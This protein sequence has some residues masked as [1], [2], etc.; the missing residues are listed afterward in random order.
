[1]PP[2]FVVNLPD[3]GEMFFRH[4]RGDDAAP[5]LVLIHGWTASADVQ[6]FTSYRALQDGYSFLAVDVRGHGR[7]LR[8]EETFTLE[9]AADDIGALLRE[10]G[11]REAILVGYSMGGPLSLLTAH[12][13]PGL[14][15]GLVLCATALDFR[16]AGDRVQW[17][18]LRVI[19]SLFRSRTWA[20][21]GRR[22]LRRL[23]RRRPD[24]APFLPWIGAELH[25]ADPVALADGARALRDYDAAPF[26]GSLG[27]P[28]A[29]LVTTKDRQVRPD[30]QVAMAE[31][32]AAPTGE[33]AGDHFA[34][35]GEAT[36]FAR[37]L[38]RLV[39]DVAGRRHGVIIPF[40]QEEPARRAAQ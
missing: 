2:A 34:C 6:W 24:L 3:R 10:L 18:F 16:S 19:E 14:V 37:M 9:D 5:T 4:H 30:K 39:D 26:A 38:R 20:W 21:V 28:A 13:H 8:S 32:L 33:V 36:D 40:G 12:R 29:V 1:V 17:L 35:W 27:L 31:V 22:S 11:L 15:S 7:G 23:E 25:R